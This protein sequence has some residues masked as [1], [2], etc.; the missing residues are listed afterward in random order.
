[1]SDTSWTSQPQSDDDRVL[2]GPA[3][4]ALSHPVRVQIVRLLRQ[5]GPST[6][7]RLAA[8]LGLN[9]GATSYHLRQLA[10]AGLVEEADDLGNKR[11][12]WWRAK[13]RSLYFDSDSFVREPEAAMG[14]F[15]AIATSYA[16]RIVEFAHQFPTL[17]GGWS[18]GA[19]IS[20]FPLHL[21]AAESERMLDEIA[22]VI[23]S[24]RRDA[25]AADTPAEAED[26]IVQLQVMPQLTEA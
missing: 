3:L 15:N 9:S 11:D 5:L 7:S 23:S 26:V 14:Y 21:T 6:A 18:N 20:D 10:A 25:H 17:P 12:R 16:E 19:T 4:V 2:D 22:A 13:V 1:M 8:S 24:Y